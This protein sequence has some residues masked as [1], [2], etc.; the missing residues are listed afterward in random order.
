MKIVVLTSGTRGDIQPFVALAIGLQTTGHDVVVATNEQYRRLVD[1][2]GL[3]LAPIHGDP[4]TLL[5][6]E[7]GKQML[8]NAGE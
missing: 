8:S 2:R 3:P 7:E 1:E 5:A 6:T 4:Q